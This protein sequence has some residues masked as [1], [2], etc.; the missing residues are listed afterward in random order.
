[1]PAFGILTPLLIATG[2]LWAAVA[3]FVLID[4]ARHDAHERRLDAARDDLA[5]SNPSLEEHAQQVSRRIGTA[6]FQQLALEGLP[7]AV[8]I[9]LARQVS[10]RA[11]GDR[12]R[13]QADGGDGVGMWKRIAA[14]QV[15]ASSG[16][17]DAYPA[18]DRALR[19]GSAPLAAAAIRMLT[20]LSGREAAVV[21][22]KAVRDGA[23]SR[24]RLAAAIDRLPALRADLLAPLF[25]SIEPQAR[26]WGVRLAGRFQAREWTPAIR[27]LANDG[28]PL[29]RRAVV[30]ALSALGDAADRDLLLARLVDPVPFVRAHAARASATFTDQDTVM[31]L[32]NLLSDQHWIVRAAARRALRTIGTPAVDALVRT[33]WDTDGFAA[34]SAA[35]VLYQT[36]TIAQLARRIIDAPMTAAEPMRSVHRYMAVA[37]PHLTHALLDRLSASERVALVR[38]LD[39]TV[40]TT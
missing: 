21:L 39:A 34:N 26:F 27:R 28:S 20:T 23:Y 14:L 18:L 1:M 31:A 25:E 40:A 17:S 29:V 37:G 22:I 15:L 13:R 6:D 12:I 19:S 16:T 32:V 24:A 2:A 8:E 30:E 35:E 33:M 7:H 9:A 38:H 36:G 3:V 10:L 5:R 11:G 4:R